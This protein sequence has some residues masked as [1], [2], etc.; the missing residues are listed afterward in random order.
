MS[1]DICINS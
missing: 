1:C